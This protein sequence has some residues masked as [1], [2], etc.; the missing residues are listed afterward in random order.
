MNNT[1]TKQESQEHY[2][3]KSLAPSALSDNDEALLKKKQ[4]STLY[5][6]GSDYVEGK[7]QIDDLEEFVYQ[8]VTA[9]PGKCWRDIPRWLHT[10]SQLVFNPQRGA[11]AYKIGQQHYDIGNDLFEAMLDQSMSYTCGYWR[12]CTSLR[13]AQLNKLDLI[14]RKLRLRKGQRVLDVGCGWG[15]FAEF[16]A[17]NYGVE[18]VGI[19]VS[20]EQARY[21]SERC[22]DLPVRI[23]LR[24][25]TEVKDRFDR[26]VSIE[27]VE[28]VGRKNLPRYF[29]C[30]H[31]SLKP[32]G[33]FVIQAISADTFSWRSNPSFDSYVTWIRENI[34]PA[35][36]LPSLRELTKP[37]KGDFVV[38]DL[39][40]FGYDYAHTLRAW[41]T[42][43]EAAW[44]QLSADY[45]EEF[46]RVWNF[47]L[48]G[49]AAVFRADLLQLYQLVFAK[50]PGDWEP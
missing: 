17:R 29:K 20:Q 47:Y 21:A 38:H 45:S 46:R 32:G 24:D 4:S 28:A 16:A 23:E 31:Q 33:I 2:A 37:H 1:A 26:V 19:T 36:Y 41:R 27:M 35:G 22:R 49:C 3:K 11:G 8:K 5:Q 6:V 40:S 50:S 44:P 12:E 14:C 10:I 25:Y 15:N 18:V 39:E 7:L 13:E 30:I 9:S 42:N 34:F 48:A 43:F